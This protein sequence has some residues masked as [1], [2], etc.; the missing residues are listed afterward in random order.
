LAEKFCVFCGQKPEKKNMEHVIPKW[1]SRYTGCYKMI[2]ALPG[3]TNRQIPFSEFKFPACTECNSLYSELESDAGRVMVKILESK[4]VNA[5]EISVLLDWFDKVRVGLWLSELTLSHKIDD[6][7]PKF[8]ISQRIGM[9]D[10][11]LIVERFKDCDSGLAFAGTAN[12]LFH[13]APN[14]FQLMVNDYVFTNVSEY[15]LVSPKLGFPRTG[16]LPLANMYRDSVP[17]MRGTN[18]TAHP[19]IKGLDAAPER[20]ILYQPM[21]RIFAT[22]DDNNPYKCD[23]VQQ[24]SL[25]PDAGIGGVFYQKGDNTIKYLESDKSVT[26]TPRPQEHDNLATVHRKVFN[27]QQYMMNNLYDVPDS[28]PQV[29]VEIKRALVQNYLYANSFAALKK[30]TK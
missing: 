24:H 27:M 8:H 7:A 6:I 28:D 11:L 3:V 25:S 23:Y 18:K 30:K 2:C 16:K 9:K 21:Y 29:K 20:T 13:Y 5:A 26:L 15:N 17:V 12:E 1:L 19:V 14:A 4:P 10:R 22:M